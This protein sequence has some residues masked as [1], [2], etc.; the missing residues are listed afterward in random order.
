MPARPSV[1]KRIFQEE[2][3]VNITRQLFTKG[4]YSKALAQYLELA[5]LVS[6]Q[7]SAADCAVFW[8]RVGSCAANAILREGGISVTEML[9]Y[10]LKQTCEGI[11]NYLHWMQVAEKE[12]PGRLTQALEEPKER[13][14]ELLTLAIQYHGEQLEEH[15]RHWIDAFAKIHLWGKAL[16]LEIT[17]EILQQQRMAFDQA[18]H[19][20]HVQTLAQVYLDITQQEEST[21]YL[22]ARA[23]VMNIL[24]DIAYFEGGEGGEEKAL[25]W[26]KQCLAI[27]PDD[28][29]AKK[30][31]SFIEQQQFVQSQIRRFQHDTN[32]AIADLR[33]S[34]KLLSS[35]KSNSSDAFKDTISRM[36]WDL[37]RVQAVHKLINGYQANFVS[38][39]IEPKIQQWLKAY[40][41]LETHLTTEGTT[42]HWESDPS[43]LGLAFHNLMKNSIEAFE[44]NRIRCARLIHIHLKL[45]QEILIFED[46]A[47]GIPSPIIERLFE[48]YVSSKGIQKETGLGLY[49]A[50]TA[51]ETLIG[52]QLILSAKQP[53]NGARFEIHLMG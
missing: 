40:A 7:Y 15:T 18:D 49:Q 50:R 2:T 29:F 32:T 14:R 26:A 36:E 3:Y 21:N 9:P 5:P 51:V 13:F 16:P 27:Y 41:N 45:D 28:A 47:G 24:S 39:P 12:E 31:K 20:K 37:D 19:L 38:F 4:Q 1:H 23:R 25:Y 10:L 11:H 17:L 52:G 35:L 22:F 33:G 48:P 8:N 34:L 46:N 53:E 6:Q 44:R 30:Q 42:T 43:Y